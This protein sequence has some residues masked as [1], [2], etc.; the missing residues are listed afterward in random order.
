MAGEGYLQVIKLASDS[1][2]EETQVQSILVQMPSRVQADEG[3]RQAGRAGL[4]VEM[5]APRAL[6]RANS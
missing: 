2:L 5:W 6:V 1:E 4:Y 3:K